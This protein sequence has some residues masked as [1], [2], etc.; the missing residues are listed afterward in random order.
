MRLGVSFFPKMASA[1]H[2]YQ[3]IVLLFLYTAPVHPVLHA[4]HV[5]ITSGNCEGKLV[6]RST[7]I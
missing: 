1:F 7:I 2:L 6:S 4:V 3:G 5:V